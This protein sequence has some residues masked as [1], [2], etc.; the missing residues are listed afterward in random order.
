MAALVG[1]RITAGL[2]RLTLAAQSIQHGDIGRRAA[3]TSDDEVGVLGAA[4]DSMA[5]SIEDKATALQAAADDET[6]LRNRLEAVVAGMGDALVAVDRDGRIT[7][8]NQAAAE[9]TGI[10]AASAQGRS[11]D[12]VLNLVGEDGISLGFRLRTPSA[13]RSPLRFRPALCGGRATTSW[14]AC[15][16]CATCRVR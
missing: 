13:A 8:F 14:A 12:E 15:W 5:A 4:F 16:C 11:A 2:R 1:D 9:L 3:I 10:S 7:D 6:R